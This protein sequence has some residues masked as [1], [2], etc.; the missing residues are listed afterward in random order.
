VKD[1]ELKDFFDPAARHRLSVGEMERI[2]HRLQSQIPELRPEPATRLF[3]GSFLFRTFS[4]LLESWVP[5]AAVVV[6]LVLTG[7]GMTSAQ[8]ALPGDTLYV[9]KRIDEQLRT[10][11]KFST[12]SKAAMEVERMG[13]R[14]AEASALRAKGKLTESNTTKLDEDYRLERRRALQHIATLE[15]QGSQATAALARARMHA[16]EDRYQKLFRG[17]RREN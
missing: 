13:V 1:R 10:S 2:Y 12:E 6:A 8:N 9:L 14:L 3:R 11:W 16:M 5:V 7:A 15:K 17:Q 4:P